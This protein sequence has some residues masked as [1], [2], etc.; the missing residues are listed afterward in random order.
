MVFCHFHC[1]PRPLL[2]PIQKLIIIGKNIVETCIPLRIV[3]KCAELLHTHVRS[4]M[5]SGMICLK[6]TNDFYSRFI[7]YILLLFSDF[8]FFVPIFFSS[9]PIEQL[10]Q[11]GSLHS[12]QIMVQQV[13]WHFPAA[14]IQTDFGN[15]VVFTNW[16]F[17][18]C[19][20]IKK[21]LLIANMWKTTN[22]SPISLLL[23][24]VAIANGAASFWSS[25]ST[26][27]SAR[28]RLARESWNK[29][30]AQSES[31]SWN[32]APPN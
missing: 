10:H 12:L 29:A 31:S 11:F 26:V 7:I 22:F 16:W 25:S 5:C 6:K 18:V 30:C 8:L 19:A 28:L 1:H 24:F 17:F 32:F 4:A 15:H 20:G 9:H 27:K 3:E 2:W 21:I 14:P 23:L 13:H